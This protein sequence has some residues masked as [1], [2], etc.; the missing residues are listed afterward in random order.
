MRFSSLDSIVPIIEND[1]VIGVTLSNTYLP[2]VDIYINDDYETF[3]YKHYLTKYLWRFNPQNKNTWNELCVNED[4][5]SSQDN[6]N[7]INA[8]TVPILA[9]NKG[10][11]DIQ[12]AINVIVVFFLFGIVDKNAV[13][14]N[15]NIAAIFL[16][17]NGNF[18]TPLV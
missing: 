8:A 15:G 4:I 3:K 7:Y 12:Y 13:I 2:E 6:N 5:V 14:E 16:N 10:I 17:T 9:D 18:C 1:K 11:L